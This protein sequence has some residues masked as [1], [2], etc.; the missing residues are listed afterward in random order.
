MSWDPRTWAIF[1]KTKSAPSSQGATA[2]QRPPKPATVNAKGDY[3]IPVESD[4]SAA[5][6]RRKRRTTRR[7]GFR[8][9]DVNTA[10]PLSTVG[11]Q[12]PLGGARGRTRKHKGRKHHTRRR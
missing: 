8:T 6:G 7:G 5:G 4:E 10:A 2:T 3:S 1:N 12:G 11:P 9:Q